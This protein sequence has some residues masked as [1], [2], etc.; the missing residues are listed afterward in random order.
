MKVA[1]I[2]AKSG[3]GFGLVQALVD[4]GASVY[5]FCRTAT[6]AL[7]DAGCAQIIEG[8]DVTDEKA[9]Q[10]ATESLDV[11]F[12]DWVFHVPGL[13][14]YREPEDLCKEKMLQQFRVNSVGVLQTFKCMAKFL[15][16]GSKFGIVSSRMGSIEDN[17]KGQWI[18]FRMSKAAANMAGRCLALENKDKE[19]AVFLLHPGFVKTEITHYEGHLEPKQAASDL[20]KL[21]RKLTLDQSGTFWHAK[22]ERLPW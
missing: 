9:L 7:K 4:E 15:R 11:D 16:K 17:T 18:G 14:Y 6:D 2:G 20:I 19:I 13:M 1:V 21:M 12:F 5:A 22:G 10:T 3:I 8:F